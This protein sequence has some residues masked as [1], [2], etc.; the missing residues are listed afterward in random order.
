MGLWQPCK[1]LKLS[2]KVSVGTQVI[3]HLFLWWNSTWVSV[4]LRAR[5]LLTCAHEQH[6]PDGS[7]ETL[8]GCTYSKFCGR[9]LC[10]RCRFFPLSAMKQKQLCC[11]IW[12]GGL[13]WVCLCTRRGRPC[14]QTRWAVVQ[15]ECERGRW[16]T[17]SVRRL[18]Y[19]SRSQMLLQHIAERPST[20]GASRRALAQF[21]AMWM[22]DDQKSSLLASLPGT[23]LPCFFS[24]KSNFLQIGELD[25]K[26]NETQ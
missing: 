16:K 10:M 19:A 17:L 15:N 3:F 18:S 13:G 6:F 8:F 11:P 25:G 12:S 14:G 5:E 2:G 26:I 9:R 24:H 21:H 1:T 22:D 23:P 7:G 20:A 4:P